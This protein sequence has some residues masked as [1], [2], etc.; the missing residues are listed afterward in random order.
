M[1]LSMATMDP[2]SISA[3]ILRNGGVVAIPTDT[4]YGLAASIAWPAA[5]DRLYE[6]KSRPTDKAIPILLSGP[7]MVSL[8]AMPSSLRLSILAD[9]FW[10]GALTIVVEARGGLPERLTSVDSRGRR[11]V[12][13]R[14]PNH[15]LTLG[16]IEAAG[17]ALAVTSA[18]RSGEPAATSAIQID[19]VAFPGLGAIVDDE[20]SALGFPSTV[21]TITGNSTEIL[22]EGAISA[23]EI[24]SFLEGSDVGA[25]A[26]HPGAV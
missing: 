25:M 12:A 5:I 13:I 24:F 9:R 14:V 19:P 7:E 4:V 26:S 15:P 23:N 11:T 21:V 22:R 16:I 8:V 10:P 6:M 20:R 18:N 1:I 2:I 17:G 3:T